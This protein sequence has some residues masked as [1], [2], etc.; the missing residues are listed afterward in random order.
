MSSNL[1]IKQ[2]KEINIYRA[3]WARSENNGCVWDIHFDDDND[4]LGFIITGYDG[5]YLENFSTR[6]CVGHT[7]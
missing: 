2:N 5:C 1:F 7:V 4:R 6:Q 3:V